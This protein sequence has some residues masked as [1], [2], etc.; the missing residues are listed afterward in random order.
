MKY[1][2]TMSQA[3]NEHHD[4]FRTVISDEESNGS[5]RV[6]TEDYVSLREWIRSNAES[7][8]KPRSPKLEAIIEGGQ[9]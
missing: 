5:L 2:S 6:K 4:R 7:F 8:P 9:S 3:R 1:K